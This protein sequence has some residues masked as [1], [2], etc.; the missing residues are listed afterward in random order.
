MEVI[1]CKGLT[2]NEHFN[3]KKSN[4]GFFK[5]QTKEQP[6]LNLKENHHHGQKN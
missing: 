2:L 5:S 1:Y 6:N 4:F 3:F